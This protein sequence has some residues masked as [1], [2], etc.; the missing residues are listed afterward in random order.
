MAATFSAS[1]V[2]SAVDK[3]SP[4]VTRMQR[5]TTMFTSKLNGV[6]SALN[7]ISRF[8]AG[9]GFL[10]ITSGIGVATLLVKKFVDESAKIESAVAGFT[11]ALGSLAKATNLVKKLNSEAANTPFQFED[12]ATAANTLISMEVSD[13][14]NV[15]KSMRMLGDLAKGNSEHLKNMSINYSE[16]VSNGKA[17]TK[18][19][20]Q[21]TT[22]GV[23]LIPKL[24]RMLNV[25]KAVVLDMASK[26]LITSSRVTKALT[27]MTSKGGRFFNAMAIASNT[28]SGRMSTLKDNISATFAEIGS[29]ALPILKTYVNQLI[30]ATQ[31]V[32]N[33]AEENRKAIKDN[34][35]EWLENMGIAIKFVIDNYASIWKW[36]KRYIAV[37]ILLRVTTVAVTFVTNLA[38]IAQWAYKAA[39][40]SVTAMVW[41]YEFATG[42]FAATQWGSVAAV[43]ASTAASY[44]YVAA[45]IAGTAATWLGTTAATAFAWAV[46][47]AI[48]PLTLIAL[49]IAAVVAIT[50]YAIKTWDEWGSI[51]ILL[52]GPFGILVSILMSLATH[53][54][55]IKKSF[56]EGGI[57]AGIHRIG[58]V[59]LD[60]VLYPLQKILELINKIPGVN[61]QGG[62]DFIS[63]IRKDLDLNV[64]SEAINNS[65]SREDSRISRE[66]TVAKTQL[67]LILNNN[68]DTDATFKNPFYPMINIS[69][70]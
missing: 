23:P 52:L 45:S 61:I 63:D 60:V 20:R 50:Y 24:A 53:W 10:G 44:G 42:V 68:T 55:S 18:D 2:F 26:G 38:T 35:T 57:L 25:S 65:Q 39:V 11:P 59:L 27:E 69:G 49:A 1:T 64:P 58:V 31:G 46:N 28:F 36:T 5:A 33:W 15:I 41:L 21:F 4:T 62:V 32:R 12:L 30:S 22:A 13:D 67:E 6:S 56:T 17:M 14:T 16:I 19:L 70:V 34:V 29:S 40:V 66:E 48:W 9:M 7:P 37:L 43:G 54:D 3:F 47:L 8:G 51:I